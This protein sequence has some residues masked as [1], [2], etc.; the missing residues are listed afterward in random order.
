MFTAVEIESPVLRPDGRRYYATRTDELNAAEVERFLRALAEL[1]AMEATPPV[2][3]D[4]TDEWLPP[5]ETYDRRTEAARE[6]MVAA[7]GV[8]VVSEQSALAAS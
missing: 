4:D 6:A 8:P 1:R 7:V 5:P 2:E 3:D